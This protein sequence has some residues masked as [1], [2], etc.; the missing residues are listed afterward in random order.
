MQ[1]KK[2]TPL[3]SYEVQRKGGEDILYI[4]Y[5]GAPFVPSIS[6][7]PEIME[8][9]ID[10]LIENQNVSRIVFVQQK[11]YNYDFKETGLLLE[12][13]QL[14]VYFVRQERVLS[15]KKLITNCEQF[16]SQRYNDIFSFL[17]LLKQDPISAYSELKKIIIEAKIF[18]EKID[19]H[20][21]TDQKNYINFLE[22]LFGLLEKTKLIQEV[23]TYNYIYKKWG[24]DI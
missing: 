3:Y 9:T 21:K 14:Y 8:R 7:Y 5:F 13:A 18:L 15:Q 4:N 23:F 24:R 2:E 1:F 12:I 19:L 6:D 16:F 22:K 20:Y 11:N 10:V 17:F